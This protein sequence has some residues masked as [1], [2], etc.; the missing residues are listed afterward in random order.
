M[1]DVSEEKQAQGL[2]E[3]DLVSIHQG[4]VRHRMPPERSACQR[5]RRDEE[6]S[7]NDAVIPVTPSPTRTPPF[8][9]ERE[10][11][12]TQRRAESGFRWLV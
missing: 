11:F 12:I 6:L 10:G 7:M 3:L 5:S 9:P 2:A 1:E 4:G 8:P